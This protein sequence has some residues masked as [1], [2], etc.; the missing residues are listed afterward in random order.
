MDDIP[1]NESVKTA[2]QKQA[3]ELRAFKNK[4]RTACFLGLSKHVRE[5]NNKLSKR[6]CAI[7]VTCHESML[8][9]VSNWN[10]NKNA[11]L[12]P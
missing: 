3:V 4:L 8:N 11:S 1:L 9:F 12:Q 7:D 5:Q 10:L 2:L 6:S